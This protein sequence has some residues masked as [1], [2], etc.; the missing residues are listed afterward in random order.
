MGKDLGVLE[1]GI[2]SPYTETVVCILK[3][4]P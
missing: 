1:E 2:W 4:P 3:E